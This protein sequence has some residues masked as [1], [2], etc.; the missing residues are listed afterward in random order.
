MGKTLGVSLTA[1]YTAAMVGTV[2]KVDLTDI[3]RIIITIS[4]SSAGTLTFRIVNSKST[5]SSAVKSVSVANKTG[6]NVTIDVSELSGEYY[7]ALCA[8]A[9]STTYYIS[10]AVS[11]VRTE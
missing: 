8:A 1:P 3:N 9:G 11:A 6:E 4:S 5:T 10:A 2:N 7:L